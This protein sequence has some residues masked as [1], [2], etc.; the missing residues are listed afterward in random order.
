MNTTHKHTYNKG[1]I[2]AGIW[3][4]DPCA[5]GKGYLLDGSA[6]FLRRFGWSD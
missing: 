1:R 3:R 5:F 4:N 6:G 2:N